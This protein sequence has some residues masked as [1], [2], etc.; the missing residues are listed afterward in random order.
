MRK[1]LRLKPLSHIYDLSQAPLNA[2]PLAG[3]WPCLN[4]MV[5]SNRIT[6]R[7]DHEVSR[8]FGSTET[9][10]EIPTFRTYDGTEYI[11]V[12]TD[13]D[14]AKI[15]GATANDTYQYITKAYTTGHITNISDTTPSVVTGTGTGW[16]TS[17][18]AAG[19][20]FIVDGDLSEAIEPDTNW[21]IIASVDSDTQLTLDRHYTGTHGALDT[22]DYRTRMIYGYVDGT[23]GGDRWQ[24]A[25][26]AGQF[27]FCNGYD[28]MQV[29]TGSGYATDLDTTYCNQVKYCVA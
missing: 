12:L 16:S 2:N 10:G 1:Q 6:R 26:V 11:L 5:S 24:Y 23:P 18:L 15:M 22:V 8:T 17:G 27:C 19:D 4:V 13:N 3:Q 29:W 9:I 14:A 21:A 7:W 20:M 25:S 28:Y